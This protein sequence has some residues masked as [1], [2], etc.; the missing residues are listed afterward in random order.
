MIVAHKLLLL[1]VT[2]V[3][4]AAT[5]TTYCTFIVKTRRSPTTTSPETIR[6]LEL[7]FSLFCL[8]FS[9]F[10]SHFFLSFLL[11]L[12]LFYSIHLYY[13]EYLLCM[14][15]APPTLF[16]FQSQPLRKHLISLAFILKPALLFLSCQGIL[17]C[18]TLLRSILI[19]LDCLLFI[20]TR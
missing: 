14:Y 17:L 5:A 19:E 11:S 1:L 6:R 8:L 3:A 9:H 18:S 4:A 2:T 7:H 16:S 12:L 10:P 15:A 13:A 20:L